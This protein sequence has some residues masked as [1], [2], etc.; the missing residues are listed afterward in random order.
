[1][2]KLIVFAAGL[3]LTVAALAQTKEIEYSFSQFSKVTAEN[4]FEVSLLVN[5]DGVYKV[6]LQVEAPYA[7]FVSAGVKNGGLE[8]S[9]DEKSVPSDL[10]KQYKGKTPVFKAVVTM[11]APP[12]EINI[13][14]KVIINAVWPLELVDAMTINASDN[15][16]VKPAT[17]NGDLLYINLDKKA[18]ADI[19]FTGKKVTVNGSGY[20]NLNM[21]AQA[22]DVDIALNAGA[23]ATVK[24]D[25]Q[26]LEYTTKGT[27]KSVLNGIAELASY[28]IN[29]SSSVNAIN[30]ESNEANIVM[31]GLCSLT[32]AATEN[33]KVSISGGANLT[34][35]NNPTFEIDNV[36]NSSIVRYTSKDKEKEKK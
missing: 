9:L 11:P 27:S 13:K 31:S 20:S 18:T 5:T 3:L 10:K 17:I 22:D 7:E 12:K 24:L 8:I 25:T 19:A 29:G 1:M 35:D 23:D 4:D 2:K 34:F 26:T 21:S 28:S 6:S 33:V 15:A 36:K 32:E 14:D 16:V 30:L